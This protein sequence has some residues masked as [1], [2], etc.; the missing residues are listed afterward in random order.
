MNVTYVWTTNVSNMRVTDT[1]NFWG[2]GDVVRGMIAANILCLEHGYSFNIDMSRHPISHWLKYNTSQIPK[3][4]EI[5]FFAA[6]EI[7]KLL[8]YIQTRKT[9]NAVLM[10]NA[11]FNE[12][13][14]HLDAAID[15][16]KRAFEPN[17]TTKKRLNVVVNN[18]KLTP[19]HK[20]LHLR[21]GDDYMVREKDDRHKLNMIDKIVSRY[22]MSK[23]LIVSDSNTIKK[24][25]QSK[26]PEAI[27]YD[28]DHITHIGRCEDKH[29]ALNTFIEMLLISSTGSIDSYTKYNHNSG[30]VGLIN[31]L[32]GTPVT[33]KQRNVEWT[34]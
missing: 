3:S 28:V 32:F 15:H 27:M 6:N 26:H 14:S 7:N 25:I 16:V 22:D 4:S 24:Y 19:E 23:T 1:A 17:D 8:K 33:Y 21:V 11:F 30:F 29:H 34:Y 2:I 12:K 18:L 13:S 10:T 31:T 20:T 5:I 9:D